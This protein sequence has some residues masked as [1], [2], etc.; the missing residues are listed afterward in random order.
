MKPEWKDFLTDA[1]AE[2]A[3]D[4]RVESFGNPNREL[5]VSPA[6]EV[7]CDLSHLGLISAH[8]EDAKAFLQGQFCNDIHHVDAQ[9]SQLSAYHTA[10]GRMLALMRIFQR[11]QGLYM[12]LPR[13][14]LED[15]LK[16]LRMFVLRSKVT[17]DDASD[18]FV[19]IGLAGPKAA[20][21]L[22]AAV[23]PFPSDPG[24]VVQVNDLTV[25]RLPGVHPRFEICGELGDIKRVWNDLNVDC[26]PVGA[27][28]WKLLN[29]RAGVPVIYAVNREAYVAQMANLDR[30][31]GISF[32]K[33]CYTGQE[34]VARMHYLGQLKQRMFAA[35]VN[36][37]AK[38]GDELFADQQPTG[39]VIEAA[40]Y[41]EGGTAVLAVMRVAA[42]DAGDVRLGAP[43]G[44]VLRFLDLP[45][46]LSD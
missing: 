43:N 6:G 46:A 8:G 35:V 32:T 21:R 44:P 16:R 19:R 33:G 30:L 15:T 12:E 20:D 37:D 1:G 18:A 14:I 3:A 45:Y 34:I 5:Q 38:P 25:L 40:A 17:L 13:D 2:F 7:I 24:K 10:K 4:G 27:P 31:G 23:G 28:V 42:H 36:S 41:P 22:H 29:I 26:A 9:H 11:D 39:K